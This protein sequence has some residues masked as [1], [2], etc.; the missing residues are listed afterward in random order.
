MKFTLKLFLI[1]IFCYGCNRP[2]LSKKEILANSTQVTKKLNDNNIDI[3]RKWNFKLIRGSEEW[4][5]QINDSI[6]YLV[7]KYKINDTIIYSLPKRHIHSIEFPISIEVDTSLLSDFA[8]IKF[9]LDVNKKLSIH[10]KDKNYKPVLIADSLNVEKFFLNENLFYKL[11]SLSKLKDEL[12]VYRIDYFKRNGNFI[13]FYITSN[14]ILTYI[15]DKSTLK[16]RQRWLD[17]FEKGTE[18]KPKWNLRHID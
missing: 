2:L 1:L 9:I 7:H 12:K 5:K 18:I 8:S 3:F 17:N 6:V 4:E 14:D 16:P 11:D 13:E 10:S 15:E